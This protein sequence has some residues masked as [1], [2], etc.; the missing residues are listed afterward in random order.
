MR[1]GRMLIPALL[2]LLLLSACPQRQT[3]PQ[4]AQ[5]EGGATR[6][7]A[8]PGDKSK[9]KAVGMSGAS[10]ADRSGQLEGQLRAQAELAKAGPQN[11]SAGMQPARELDR[12][13]RDLQQQMSQAEAELQAKMQAQAERGAAQD[14]RSEGQRQLE[15]YF[16]VPR[17]APAAVSVPAAGSSAAEQETLPAARVQNVRPIQE[18]VIG[19]APARPQSIIPLYPHYLYWPEITHYDLRNPQITSYELSDRGAINTYPLTE[20]SQVTDYGQPEDPQP[21]FYP[22][23]ERGEVT[24]YVP[25]DRSEVTE[26]QPEDRSQITQYQMT[27]RSEL[28][29]VGIYGNPILPGYS[30]L[31]SGYGTILPQLPRHYRNRQ[32]GSVIVIGSGDPVILSSG[33]TLSGQISLPAGVDLSNVWIGVLPYSISPLQSMNLG[34]LDRIQ[35]QSADGSFSYTASYPGSYVFRV[36]A[37]Y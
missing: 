25:E 19:S 3:G 16:G 32:R 34:Q 26:Y 36:F 30:V 17:K 33:E 13:Q 10:G 12:R 24:Q 20:R 31:L 29:S 37:A 22:L 9:P 1:L 14:R 5:Y 11:P 35:L 18:T 23:S 21:T 8:Q 28:S 27:D 7:I 15:D 2:G 6:G 4:V